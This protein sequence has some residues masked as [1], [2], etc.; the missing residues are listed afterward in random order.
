MTFTADLAEKLERCTA[1]VTPADKGAALQHLAEWLF[2]TANGYEVISIKR[3]NVFGS[4]EIDLSVYQNPSESGAHFI[5][6]FFL[7]EC[8]N[9][10][11]SVPSD[12]VDWFV[13]KLRR[14]NQSF[15]V[16]V[17]LHGISGV[18][19]APSYAHQIV[20]AALQ[21][22]IRIAVLDEIDLRNLTAADQ[23]TGLIR[24]KLGGLLTAYDL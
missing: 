11:S 7:V 14:R 1:A 6:P 24:N 23:I 18:A 4:E 2:S 22:G 19:S 16:L 12:Q 17:T 10:A 15:G 13:G 8:K 20:A 3:F 21:E 5:E 9:L